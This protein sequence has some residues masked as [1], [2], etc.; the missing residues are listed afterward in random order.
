MLEFI[1]VVMVVIL[2]IK[3]HQVNGI[4]KDVHILKR[5]PH[6][7]AEILIASFVMKLLEQ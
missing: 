3:Y 2:W 6:L 5:M 4:V 7:N 1:K